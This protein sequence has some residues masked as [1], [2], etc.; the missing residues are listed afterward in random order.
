M[1]VC[2]IMTFKPLDRFASNFRELGRTT[3]TFLAQFK[4][5]VK[6]ANFK[7]KIYFSVRAGFPVYFC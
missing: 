3:G 1:F 7:G 6:K 5:D 2:P 4:F